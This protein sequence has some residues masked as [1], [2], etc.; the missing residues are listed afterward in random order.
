MSA[1]KLRLCFVMI[2]ILSVIIVKCEA[3]TCNEVNNGVTNPKGCTTSHYCYG[4]IEGEGNNAKVYAGCT[5]NAGFCN[6]KVAN[7]Q[8]CRDYNNC[9]V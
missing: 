8:L 6:G 4:Y 1:F 2:F 7:C 5:N 3:L 9:N